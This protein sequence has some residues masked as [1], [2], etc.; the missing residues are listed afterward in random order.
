MLA[1][2]EEAF[3]DRA[4][5]EDRRK[6]F[7]SDA[8]HELRTPLA[9]LRGYAELFR[10]GPA[11]DPVALKRAM[12]RIE[13]EAARMGALVDNLLLLARLDEVP[14]AQHVPVNL[15]EL[16]AHAVADAQATAPEREIALDDDEPLITIGHPDGLRQVLANLMSNALTHT[17][18][19]TP[20]TVRLRRADNRA[21]LEV[22]DHGPGLPADADDRVFDRFWRNDEG[23]TR[24]RGGAGL[25]LAIVREIVQAHHGTVAAANAADGGAV[26]TVRLPLAPRSVRPTDGDATPVAAV[27]TAV[28]S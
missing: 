11:Q 22:H 13:A 23:R 7:L 10:M 2:I 3:A 1:R 21:I 25:G 16:A 9:S 6:R 18:E 15:N 8:S 12:A 28:G 19:G 20:V 4:R 26:F 17:P 24:G 14:E 27:G 5:S